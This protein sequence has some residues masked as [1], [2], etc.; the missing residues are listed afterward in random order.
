MKKAFTLVE[1]LI[2][3]VVLVTLMSI[4]FK[5]SSIGNDQSARNTAV[6]RLQRLENCLSG[7]YAAF[8]TYPPVRLH[9]SRNYK[10]GVCIHGI[11][12]ESESDLSWNWFNSADHRVSDTENERKDWKKVEAACKAQPLGCS[13]PYP[14]DWS[15]FLSE[16]SKDMAKGSSKLNFSNFSTGGAGGY[17]DEAEWRHVQIFKFGLMSF[18]LPRYLVMMRG[19]ESLY[20]DQA[21]WLDNNALPCNPLTGDRYDDRAFDDPRSDWGELQSD[22]NS[23]EPMKL[24]R[25]QNIPSQAACARWMPNLEG[26]CQF[27]RD[28]RKFFGI[29]IRDQESKD[30]TGI[31]LN[32][33][34]E[35]HVLGDTGGNCQEAGNSSGGSSGG[36]YPLDAVTVY[37]GF[38]HADEDGDGM[39]DYSEFFYYSPEPYQSYVLW[40]AGPNGRTF[41]PWV[42]R[43]SLTPAARACVGYWTED[44]IVIM[45]H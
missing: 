15:D 27:N 22:A 35:L 26:I 29:D 20:N 6:A 31:S 42:P 21:Q 44:D 2:V 32:R 18:L 40:S 11:Q 39:T 8:G 34:P 36:Q 30:N 1:L 33:R 14:D 37:D 43:E 41:P 9:G 3:V 28:D 25:V 38:A 19:D 12:G 16:I 45:S 24:A 7:Y 23:T 17:N 4:T 5:L 10:L 13:Y